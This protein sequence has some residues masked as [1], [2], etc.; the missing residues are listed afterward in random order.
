MPR[1]ISVMPLPLYLV[2]K[3]S[4]AS[5][6][7]LL[8]GTHCMPQPTSS[9]TWFAMHIYWARQC[10]LVLFQNIVMVFFCTE[11][12]CRHIF[13]S[14]HLTLINQASNFPSFDQSCADVQQQEYH[15]NG[16]KHGVALAK[17]LHS[18]HLLCDISGVHCCLPPVLLVDAWEL[19]VFY[20][21]L[22]SDVWYHAP[23]FVHCCC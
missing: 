6:N 9:S 16:A 8:A 13:F 20:H 14:F 19:H 4:T 5:C 10:L 7:F 22:N 23:S 1:S 11:C 3:Y 17:P 15:A 2:S 12:R 18:G 21:A